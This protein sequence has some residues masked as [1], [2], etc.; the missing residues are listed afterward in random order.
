MICLNS[1]TF[2]AEIFSFPERFANEVAK[3]IA[4]QVFRL[5]SRRVYL[6]LSVVADALCFRT[7]CKKIAAQGGCI[8]VI[9]VSACKK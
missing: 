6:E 3:R 5:R 4:R 9:T 7:D 2:V 8:T 1:C